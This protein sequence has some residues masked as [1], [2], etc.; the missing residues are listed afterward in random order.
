M[1]FVVTRNSSAGNFCKRIFGDCHKFFA[2][3]GILSENNLRVPFEG[4][5]KA[6]KYFSS[7][8]PIAIPLKRHQPEQKCN[9]IHFVCKTSALRWLDQFHARRKLKLHRRSLLSLFHL[10]FLQQELI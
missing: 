5:I 3:S 1:S 4:F 8:T 2:L 6:H 7:A 10:I 9:T